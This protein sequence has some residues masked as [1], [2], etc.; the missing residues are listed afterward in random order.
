MEGIQLRLDGLGNV[1]RDGSETTGGSGSELR[2][3][4]GVGLV[5]GQASPPWVPN[6]PGDRIRTRQT[7][8]SAGLFR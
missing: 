2:A 4:F 1:V 6:R 5:V 3:E 8:R 7:Q